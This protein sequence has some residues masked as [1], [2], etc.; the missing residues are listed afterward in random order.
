ME[1]MWGQKP[2]KQMR[3][4]QTASLSPKL[5]KEEARPLIG[6]NEARITISFK[7]IPFGPYFT[8]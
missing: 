6:T 8:V 2:G 7:Q 5:H 3:S 4:L 1:N